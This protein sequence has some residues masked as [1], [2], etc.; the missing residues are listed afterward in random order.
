MKK[1]LLIRRIIYFL[2]ITGMLIFIYNDV[3]E[4]KFILIPFVICSASLL[5][6]N[7][8]LLFDNNNIA[9]FNKIYVIGFLLFWVGFLI[10][11]CYICLISKEYLLLLFTIPFWI[12]GIYVIRKRLK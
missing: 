1:I 7:I 3:T 9:I 4:N 11:Y 5:V 12:A 2:V 8:L 6:K 10:F